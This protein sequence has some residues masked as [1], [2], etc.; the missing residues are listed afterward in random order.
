MSFSQRL[1]SNVAFPLSKQSSN[2]LTFNSQG[3]SAPV[4]H[5]LSYVELEMSL[6]NLGPQGYRNVCFG[7]GGDFYSPSA[8][9]R[10]SSLVEPHTGKT[11]CN[12]QYVNIVNQALQHYNQGS[13]TVRVGGVLANGSAKFSPQSETMLST[14]Y[15]EYPDNTIMVRLPVSEIFPGDVGN[16]E[17]YPLTNDTNYNMLLEPQYKLFQRCV[18]QG[19]YGT[20]TA[21]LDI[22]YDFANVTANSTTITASALGTVANFTVGDTVVIYWTESSV[23]KVEYKT[24][25]SITPDVPGSPGTPGAIVVNSALSTNTA[26]LPYVAKFVNTNK[27]Q[28][29]PVPGPSDTFELVTPEPDSKDLAIGTVCMLHA[30]ALL[31]SSDETVQI[32]QKVKISNVTKSGSNITSINIVDIYGNALQVGISDYLIVNGYLEPLYQNLDLSD[33]TVSNSHLVLFHTQ[34]NLKVPKKMMVSNFT[35]SSVQ[36]LPN[37]TKFVYS[38]QIPNE[39]YNVY[40]LL[41]DGDSLFSTKM[42]IQTY[43]LSVNEVPLSSVYLDLDSSLHQDNVV[44][45]LDNSPNYKPNC[46]VSKRDD[47]VNNTIDVNMIVGKVHRSEINNEPNVQAPGQAVLRVELNPLTVTQQGTI[48]L[49]SEKYQQI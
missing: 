39:A 14:F 38:F 11:H 8:I 22:G 18:P 36:V 33:W 42:G 13:E 26:T 21:T 44:R 2:I 34:M 35:S 4:N 25:T 27:L 23:E 29:Q 1:P 48:F 17:A 16:S 41:N 7:R 30:T 10:N 15:N 49:F 9:V 3:S 5:S 20:E 32:V 43:L 24:I 19:V 46:L 47:E 6:S 28:L 45:V 31:A 37:T 12:L 40:A